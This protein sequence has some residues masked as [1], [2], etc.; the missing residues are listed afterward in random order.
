MKAL[1]EDSLN[2]YRGPHKN[3]LALSPSKSYLA[4]IHCPFFDTDFG[5]MPGSAYALV[6]PRLPT[7]PKAL[8]HL[9]NVTLRRHAMSL[10]TFNSVVE[11][12][13]DSAKAPAKPSF[14]FFNCCAVLATFL[15]LIPAS[16]PYV[17][18]MIKMPASQAGG[19]RAIEDTENYK[20]PRVDN[21]DCEG[22]AAESNVSYKEVAY[23]AVPTDGSL[24]MTEIKTFPVAI[25]RREANRGNYYPNH[26]SDFF[27]A[28]T[29]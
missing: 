14:L 21:Q 26:K 2:I 12:T 10:D 15:A 1:Q 22:F 6:S 27:H 7:R 11:A 18:D 25:Q 19:A 20:Q 8:M 5:T 16:S 9:L 4:D 17:S 24:N 3:P 28:K 13:L 29:E 23:F